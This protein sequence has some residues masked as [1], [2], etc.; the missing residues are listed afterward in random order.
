[1]IPL[2]RGGGRRWFTLRAACRA[3][4]SA[5]LRK[6]RGCDY[7]KDDMGRYELPCRLH[8]PDMSRQFR[9]RCGRNSSRWLHQSFLIG[10][11][12]N[13][14]TCRHRPVRGSFFVD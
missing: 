11:S 6:H 1:M 12:A 13:L 10:R 14:L 8:H 3:E 2:L 4:A 5:L 9:K 7:C